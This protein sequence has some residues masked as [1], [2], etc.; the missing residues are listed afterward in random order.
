MQAANG[1]GANR[2][3][4]ARIRAAVSALG[5]QEARRLDEIL[6]QAQADL[7]EA[8]ELLD[9]AGAGT[10]GSGLL[11]A[12]VK[13]TRDLDAFAVAVSV[14]ANEAELQDLHFRRELGNA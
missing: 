4:K 1:T 5:S 12:F 8:F 14:G 10:I 2:A 9:A 7:D 6:S 13:C 11:G 3:T